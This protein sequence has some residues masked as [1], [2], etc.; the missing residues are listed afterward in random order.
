[1]LRQWR[2]ITL[3]SSS[4]K[5]LAHLISARLKPFMHLII[6]GSQTA[7]VQDRC[8]LDNVFTFYAAAEWAN[9][10]SQRLAVLLLDFE[11]AYE[12]IVTFLRVPLS[13]WAFRMIELEGF[14][15]CT[16]QPPVLLP[17]EV[18]LA[19]ISLWAGRLD[20]DAPLPPTFSY[21][22]QRLYLHTS[23]L[24]LLVYRVFIFLLRWDS[25]L[26]CWTLS[27]QMTLF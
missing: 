18:S 23:P 7:F 27:M 11:K 12:W 21:F 10:T 26:S 25:R 17:L 14:L 2:P 8:I 19:G 1:M 16:A 3:L 20:R 22:L 24:R 15:G 4:Y 13:D 5:L 6:H 9:A